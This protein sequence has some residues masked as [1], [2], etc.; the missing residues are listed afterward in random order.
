M[1][2]QFLIAATFLPYA[3]VSGLAVSVLDFLTSQIQD[4]KS[5]LGLQYG[6]LGS[7]LKW[8]IFWTLGAAIGGFVGALAQILQTTVTAALAIA[9]TWPFILREIAQKLQRSPPIQHE[10][11]D[12]F[13]EGVN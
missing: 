7:A 5:V 13:E 2:D 11:G 6:S 10:L 9:I 4:G 12:V 8:I 1:N 3:A